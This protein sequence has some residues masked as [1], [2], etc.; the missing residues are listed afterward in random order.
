MR[1]YDYMII[2]LYDYRTALLTRINFSA[3]RQTSLLRSTRQRQGKPSRLAPH[4]WTRPS[5]RGRGLAF[6]PS[7]CHQALFPCNPTAFWPHP[8]AVFALAQLSVF[9]IIS[10]STRHSSPTVKKEPSGTQALC[11]F[12]IL[13]HYC[14]RYANA[15]LSWYIDNI[16][17]LYCCIIVLRL[18]MTISRL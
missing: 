16:V 1:F 6:A 9:I 12:A 18:Y 14:Y 8:S 7:S 13:I 4:S 15:T 2:W 3:R 11:G 10:R 17:V 5:R